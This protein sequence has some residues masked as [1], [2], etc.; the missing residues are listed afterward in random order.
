[1]KTPWELNAQLLEQLRGSD[2]RKTFEATTHQRPDHFQRVE[3]TRTTFGI[4]QLRSFWRLLGRWRSLCSWLCNSRRRGNALGRL[5][6]VLKHALQTAQVAWFGLYGERWTYL[7][8]PPG[9][10]KTGN[11]GREI[12]WFG[13]YAGR[14]F[15]IGECHQI[16]LN[17]AYLL[18]ELQRI[19]GT[20]H[21]AQ[22]GFS[23]LRKALRLQQ[24]FTGVCGGW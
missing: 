6:N 9:A 1:M 7:A 4:D 12:R 18:E 2:I 23:G 5:C 10:R 8:G 19:Q 20:D 17:S 21:L 3:C 15:P 24:P 22:L 11:K 14:R 16:R 13:Y